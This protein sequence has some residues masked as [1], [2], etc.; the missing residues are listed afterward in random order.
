MRKTL[1]ALLIGA[2]TLLAACGGSSSYDDA[3]APAAPAAPSGVVPPG[4]TAS[5]QAFV[6]FIGGLAPSERDAPLNIDAAVPPTS[7]TAAPLPVN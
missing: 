6:A 2:A 5:I 7:E 1:P 4:A 3:E